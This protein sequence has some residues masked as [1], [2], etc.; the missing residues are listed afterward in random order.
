MFPININKVS[1][2]SNV[3]KFVSWISPSLPDLTI[4]GN[5]FSMWCQ[6]QN[7]LVRTSND[8]T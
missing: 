7:V 3:K 2:L 6:W 4:F 8:L 1:V 5:Y